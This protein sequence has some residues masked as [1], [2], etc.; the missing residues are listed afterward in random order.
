MIKTL[1]T[2]VVKGKFFGKDGKPS[3]REYTFYIA[4]DVLVGDVLEV[5]TRGCNSDVMITKI[6]VDP[7]EIEPYKNVAKTLTPKPRE[8]KFEEDADNE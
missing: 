7:E 6:N 3:G 2:N 5:F 8:I 4:E 1:T